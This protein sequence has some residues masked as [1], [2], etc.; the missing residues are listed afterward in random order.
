MLLAYAVDA[1]LAI[2]VLEAVV[3][4]VRRRPGLA[5]LLA[6]LAA[7]LSLMLALRAALADAEWPVVVAALTAAGAAHAL[8]LALRMR[9]GRA[10]SP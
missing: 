5:P 1:A 9:Q 10:R 8:E 2:I 7:G 3:L 4:I 6:N